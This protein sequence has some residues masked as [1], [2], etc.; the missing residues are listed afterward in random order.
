MLQVLAVVQLCKKAKITFTD[1]TAGLAAFTGIH[2][3]LRYT[4]TKDPAGDWDNSCPYTDQILQTS[5]ES[6]KKFLWPDLHHAAQPNSIFN[7][8][9]STEGRQKMKQARF[10]FSDRCGYRPS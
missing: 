3:N 4:N 10:R 2:F 1:M 7:G 6:A 9:S 5:T 8:L